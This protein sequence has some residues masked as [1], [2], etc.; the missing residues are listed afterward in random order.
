MR[1][2]DSRVYLIKSETDLNRLYDDIE[3]ALLHGD[4]EV[5][6]GDYVPKRSLDQNRLMWA[7]LTAIG[8]MIG[9]TAN[10]MHLYYRSKFLKPA[11]KVIMGQTFYELPSTTDLS[12]K[13]MAE[14]IT[15]IEVH[16]AENGYVLPA[17]HYRE[18]ALYGEK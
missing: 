6:F 11:L 10:E 9:H 8:N 3:K 2:K 13:E 16:A 12:V 7:Y 1:T 17:P 4:V 5:E 18:F 14:Y 15:N